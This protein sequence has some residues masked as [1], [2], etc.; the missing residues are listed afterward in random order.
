MLQPG[1]PAVWMDGKLFEEGCRWLNERI[2]PLRRSS[3][4]WAQAA[5]SLL[6]W[7]DFLDAVKI[8]WKYAARDDLVAYRD[9]YLGAVSLHT[10]KEYSANTV[11]VR[12]T[13]II[14]FIRF[15][16]EN[17]WIDSDFQIGSI[18]PPRRPHRTTIGLSTLAQN[19]KGIHKS[20]AE[21]GADLSK[22]KPKVGR[23]DTV[24][25]LTRHEL[26]SLL[27][28]AGPRPSERTPSD[29]GSDRDFTVFALGWACGLRVQEIADIELLPILAIT[30]S[31][32]APGQMH[33]LPIR[34][35]GSK[36]RMI[37]IPAWLVLDLQAYIDGERKRSMHRRGRKAEE[38][39]LILNSEHSS[40]AGK[41]MTKSAMQDLM[42]RACAEA[43]L[44]CKVRKINPE[45]NQAVFNLVPKYSMHSLR[46]TYAVMSY[47]N[48]RKSG[49]AE[50]DAWKYI[51]MQ[52]GHNS[53]TTTINSYLNHLAVWGDYRIAR[54]LLDMVR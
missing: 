8:D 46:H 49:Y 17:A 27:R 13:Y 19:P 52:L 5:Q 47:H 18:A 35:K 38:K 11:G 33:K 44:M 14:D 2:V 1:H 29:G 45:T 36:L 12:M 39:Q 21:A 15:A 43:G 3:K 6:T 23:D 26:A 53:P 51:Q 10:G 24:R 41:P 7:L 30:A 31:S 32:D 16:V 50:L 34:G 54:S 28:W 37:D 42:K 4:T 9:A 25:T 22:L 48:H 20:T 40:R